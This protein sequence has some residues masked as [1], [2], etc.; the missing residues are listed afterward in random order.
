MSNRR[1][2][3]FHYRQ[4]LLQMQRG[5]SDR[6]IALGGNN[7]R[8]KAAQLRCHASSEGWLDAGATLATIFISPTQS[9]SG[10]ESSLGGQ[11]VCRKAL[12][13]CQVRRSLSER[14]RFSR[15]RKTFARKVLQF[16]QYTTT[17]SVA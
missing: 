4:A 12:A 3:V 6:A 8:K 14:L 13:K 17:T 11:C 10:P 15:Y 2:E 7:G 1:I 9:V 5:M 16:L